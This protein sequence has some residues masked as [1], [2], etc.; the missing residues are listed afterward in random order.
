MM[1][2]DEIIANSRRYIVGRAADMAFGETA[3]YWPEQPNDQYRDY[4]NIDPNMMAEYLR[5]PGSWAPLQGSDKAMDKGRKMLKA[6]N[7]ALEDMN[8]QRALRQQALDE[9][10]ASNKRV[11]IEGDIVSSLPC[12]FFAF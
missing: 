11:A 7:D 12:P 10:W 6:L 9:R 5:Q 4:G 1:A 8:A 2:D 3:F